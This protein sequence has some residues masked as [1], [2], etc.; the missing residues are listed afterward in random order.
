[1]STPCLFCNRPAPHLLRTL[2]LNRRVSRQPFDYYRCKHC[3]LIFLWPQPA[4]LDDYYPSDYYHLPPTRVQL[5]AAGEGERYKLELLRHGVREGRLLEIGPAYGSFAYLAR[6]EGFAVDAIEMDERCCE[7]LGRVAG[8]NAIH[9]A[10]AAASLAALDDYDAITLW[11]VVEHLPDLWSLL[12]LAAQKLKSGGA[13]AISTPNPDSFQFWA[14]G[15][16]WP[17][18]DAPRHLQ[19]IP[20]PLLLGHLRSLG[21]APLL[22]TTSDAG[23]FGW[24]TFGWQM[25][26][27]NALRLRALRPAAHLV[28]R[29]VSVALRPVER[30]GGRGSAYTIVMRKQDT[31]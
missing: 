17:H 11:H 12:T 3:G 18:I 5:A 26:L 2:D 1:M 24:N 13:L 25:S 29:V 15:R 28:G 23:G 30:G 7:Y 31:R 20:A 16:Y 6:R 22:F 14:L 19:L 8:V 9:S 4:N 27:V 21:L 10:D